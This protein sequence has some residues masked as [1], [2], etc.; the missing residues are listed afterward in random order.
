MFMT[1]SMVVAKRGRPSAESPRDRLARL[2]KETAA[3]RVAVREEQLRRYTILGEAIAAEA[4][5]N[6]ELKAMISGILA[7]RIKSP[8]SKADIAPFL[9]PAAAPASAAPIHD[10]A[11]KERAA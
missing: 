7:R 5:D 2:E 6:P 1:A 9:L 10:T 11:E 4:E 8:Q 3:A